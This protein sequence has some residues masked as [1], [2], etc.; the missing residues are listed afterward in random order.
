LGIW[1]SGGALAQQVQSHEF[2]PQRQKKKKKER[3]KE[4]ELG[5]VTSLTELFFQ[6]IKPN[7]LK[8]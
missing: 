2:G 5:L 1:L 3:K 8:T 4:K 7:I 6:N